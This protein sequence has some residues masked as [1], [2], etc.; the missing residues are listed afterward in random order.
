M[1]WPDTPGVSGLPRLGL[2]L[3][4]PSLR[5]PAELRLRFSSHHSDSVADRV[6]QAGPASDLVGSLS[7][8]NKPGGYESL[9]A[10]KLLKVTW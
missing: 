1:Q 5:D 10:R 8:H 9:P 4:C 2:S 7:L 3:E 6:P